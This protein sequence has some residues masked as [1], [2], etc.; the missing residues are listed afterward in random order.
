MDHRFRFRSN[1]INNIIL[2]TLKEHCIHPQEKASSSP[3][4]MGWR[5]RHQ[6]SVAL[7]LLSQANGWLL[8]KGDGSS[9]DLE[10]LSG[11]YRPPRLLPPTHPPTKASVV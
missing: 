5:G 4:W 9:D 1:N 3:G 7:G 11:S 6:R 10:M 8:Q 2:H